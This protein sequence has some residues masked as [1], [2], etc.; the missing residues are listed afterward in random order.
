MTS[1]DPK[2]A[3]ALGR[4]LPLRAE[5]EP[6]WND[7][8]ARAGRPRSAVRRRPR[9]RVFASRW[10][11]VGALIAAAGLSVGGLAI[12]DAFGPLHGGTIYVD[13]TTVGGPNGISSCGLIGKPAGQVASTLADKRV[14][15]EW[16]FTHWGTA[17]AT[18]AGTPAPATPQEK[19]QASAQGAAQTVG[20]AEAVTG[21]S[22]D[23]VS[24]VPDD[25]TVWDVVP[26][27]Q[28]KAFVFVEAPNDPNAPHVSTD[29]CS[30]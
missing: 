13:A 8:V 2:L 26:D 25:S 14:G 23:A 22:S 15:I 12:A 6:R 10:A 20:Q 4:E 17:V 27:G 29:N 16:R 24:S 1:F 18:A 21:G 19:A 28:T 11:L 3:D 9:R 5:L 7:V 30:N